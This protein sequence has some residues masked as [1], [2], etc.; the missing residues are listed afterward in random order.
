MKRWGCR[1]LQRPLIYH[2]QLLAGIKESSCIF[3]CVDGTSVL[4]TLAREAARLARKID[5]YR[6]WPTLPF[7]RLALLIEMVAAPTKLPT[8]PGFITLSDEERRVRAEP[9][10]GRPRADVPVR[11][12]NGPAPI[13]RERRSYYTET[14][15]S[16]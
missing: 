11:R 10:P 6:S 8:Q 4:G 1:A 12:A 7:L 3:T 16:L 15:S 13:C 9:P 14:V 2:I 5:S